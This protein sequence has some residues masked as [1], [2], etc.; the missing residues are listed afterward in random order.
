MSSL[1]AIECHVS[2]VAV[3]PVRRPLVTRD[4]RA[5]PARRLAPAVGRRAR[6][7]PAAVAR[8][9]APTRAALPRPNTLD[10]FTN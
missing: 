10:R 4:V 5:L 3:P 9:L 7:R 2:A 6:H 8:R 1:R